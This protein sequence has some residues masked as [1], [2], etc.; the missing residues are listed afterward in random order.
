MDFESISYSRFG[1]FLVLR[2]P[3]RPPARPPVRPSGGLSVR[4]SGPFARPPARLWQPVRA[5][6]PF[7]CPPARPPASGGSARSARPP[8]RPSAGPAACQALPRVVRASRPAVCASVRPLPPVRPPSKRKHGALRGF[9]SV[10]IAADKRNVTNNL[11][12]CV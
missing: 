3:V 4:A 2:P 12:R 11:K 7:A 1:C 6:T 8:V 10:Q 5:S 9:V